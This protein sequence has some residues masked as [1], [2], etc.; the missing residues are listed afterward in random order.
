MTDI[1][2]ADC[3]KVLVP[4]G[5][6]E[7]KQGNMCPEC[8]TKPRIAHMSGHVS[9]NFT[10]TGRVMQYSE[11]LLETAKGLI[12][13]GEPSIA[14]VVIHMACEVAV[15]RVLS[16]AFNSR[17]ITGDLEEAISAMFPSYNLSND[18]IRDLFNALHGR[19]IQNESFWPAFKQS[20]T[21]RNKIIHN[22]A[23]ATE[24][25]ANTSHSTAVLLLKYLS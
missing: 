13:S 4:D 22:G 9:M 14:T 6:A 15:E 1:D 20:A 7:L 5:T 2:C 23:T 21:R 12:A 3:G 18:R 17:R 25:E 16:Q 24:A 8:Q 19:E 11:L 10:A